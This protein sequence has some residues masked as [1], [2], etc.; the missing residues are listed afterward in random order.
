ML[1]II[2]LL[3]EEGEGSSVDVYRGVA[4]ETPPD[5]QVHAAENGKRFLG[6]FVAMAVYYEGIPFRIPG[7]V[8]LG[9]PLCLRLAGEPLAIRMRF[10]YYFVSSPA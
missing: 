6:K 7:S 5:C 3:P 2:V 1:Y 8:L 10:P 4:G 9:W